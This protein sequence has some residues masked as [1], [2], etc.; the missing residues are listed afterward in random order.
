MSAVMLSDAFLPPILSG[1]AMVFASGSQQE[2]QRLISKSFKIT[3]ALCLFPLAFI[4]IFGPSMVYA[5]TGQSDSSLRIALWLV[6]AAGFF[7]AFSILGLVLY[8]VSGKAL[9][10]NIRQVVRIACL[11]SIVAFARHW[12]FY[13]L[14]AGLAV[15]E[16]I[17]MVFMLYAITKT[18]H[19]F[20]PR[21]LLPDALRLTVASGAVL[22]AGAI[23]TQIPLPAIANARWLAVLELGKVSLACLLAT[24]PA[25]ALTKSVTGAE[26]R[27]LVNILI[28]RWMRSEPRC[29]ESVI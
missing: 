9:L 27:A 12:G 19:A 14:L 13:G 22:L 1:G 18:F 26:G 29:A 15:T 10:D 4:A 28:P 7:Q 2:M 8:R 17:G 24:W 25:L 23:A 5:W 3:L 6:C 21:L 11:L 20:H 16:F